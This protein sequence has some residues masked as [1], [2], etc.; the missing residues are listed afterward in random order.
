MLVRCRIL[1][2]RPM[3][4]LC[5]RVLSEVVS[6]HTSVPLLCAAI[7]DIGNDPASHLKTYAYVE[8]ADGTEPRRPTL[9]QLQRE[10]KVGEPVRLTGVAM[11]GRT[12]LR[13]VEYWVRAVSRMDS[14]KPIPPLADDDPELLAGPWLPTQIEP[15]PHDWAAALPD[16]TDP[17]EIHGFGADGQPLRWPLPMSYVGWSVD[18][19][20]LEPGEYEL[21]ARTVDEAGNAQPQPRPTQKSGRNTIGCRRITILQ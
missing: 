8:G 10:F 7:D 1:R 17:A 4:N 2:L 19:T 9:G 13:R 18:I 5:L 3:R 11:N 15:A 21:R 16:G 12:P 20:G 6:V 14:A